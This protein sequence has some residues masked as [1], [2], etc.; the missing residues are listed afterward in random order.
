MTAKWKVKCLC[1]NKIDTFEDAKSITYARW[2]IIGWDVGT[3][4]PKVSCP[5]CDYFPVEQK[6]KK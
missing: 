5:A 1:C 2:R 4:E 3:A 6:K